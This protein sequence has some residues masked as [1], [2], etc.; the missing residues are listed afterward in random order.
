MRYFFGTFVLWIAIFIVAG[1][2][3]VWSGI[4]NIAADDHHLPITASLINTLR[5]RSI[6]MRD[7]N[8]QMPTLD[9]PA[10]I[11][12]GARLYAKHCA[13]CHRAPGMPDTDAQRRGLYPQPPLLAKN[14][15]DDPQEAF[16]YVKH[17]I[18]MTAMPAW[19]LTFDDH[20]IWSLVSFISNRLPKLTAAQYQQITATP[21][22]GATDR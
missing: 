21:S 13:G 16:W 4:Y 7:G 8:E 12:A 20:K 22:N 14:G 17:G 1:A 2:I 18:K 10:L 15:V 3:F 9:D 19:G 6:A 11:S 5:D